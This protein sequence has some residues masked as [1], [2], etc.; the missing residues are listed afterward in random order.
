MSF[1]RADPSDSFVRRLA[2]MAEHR[3]IPGGALLCTAGEPAPALVLIASGLVE[4]VADSQP[5]SGV[6]GCGDPADGGVC[7]VSLRARTEVHSIAIP[8][9]ALLA[10]G[11]LDGAAVERVGS[12]IVQVLQRW[13]LV[14]KAAALFGPLDASAIRQLEAE[15]RWITLPRGELLVRQGDRGDSVFVLLAGRLQ[16][17]LEDPSGGRTP[18][19]EIAT[20]EIIG[21][22]SFFTGEPRSA[23]LCAVRDSL[24]IEIPHGPLERLIAARPEILRQ[25]VRVQIDRVRR[26][27]AGRIARAPVTNIAV[28]P[29]TPEVPAAA[30]CRRLE[31]ALARFGRVTHLDPATVNARL[32]SAT[33]A[34]TPEGAPEETRL[35]AWL[36][37]QELDARFVVYENTPGHDDWLSRSIHQADCV[38]LLG[39]ATD[40]PDVTPFERRAAQEEDADAPVRRVLVL[41]HESDTLPNDTQAWLRARPVVQHHHLRWHRDGDVARLARFLADQ[42]VGIVLGGGG[43]RGFAHIGILKALAEAGIP[44]DLIGGTSMGAAMAAQ[45]AMGW[46]P[47][48]IARTNDHIWNTIKP[49]KEYTLPILSLVRAG[50]ALRCGQM[51]YGSSRIED[52]WLPFFCVSSDLT[53]AA[54]HVHRSGPLL[55]AITASSSLP[56][57][58]VPTVK[59]GHL[60]CD[61]ALFN[62]LPGDVAREL[63]CGTL[64]ALRVSLEQDEAF[65]Y[66]RIP[67]LWEVLRTKVTRR[68]LRY[69]GLGDVL[70]RGAMLASIGRENAVARSADLLFVPPVAQYG[71]ME[72]S[73]L[74]RLVETGYRYAVERITEWERTG[75]LDRV[76][77]GAASC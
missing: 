51:M 44:T 61:G 12:L 69:P 3:S 15:V 57:V 60:L 64:I 9:E 45:H 52:L 10:E 11:M 27:N 70:L 67:S 7:R 32:Q 39:R 63:G 71:L 35:L 54:M 75:V 48:R 56:G 17:L 65:R 59:D 58:I 36:G 5:Y 31:A 46:S 62:N 23:S 49:H 30:F 8:S 53:A 24:L 19:G 26:A 18:V 6:V 38:L 72:F 55:E 76:P 43:A 22:M 20:G 77:H 1:A 74:D 42:A 66:A 29:L 28:V 21:E 68:P 4:T 34:H 33:I 50:G 37:E 73:A 40:P 25:V 41:L 16:A 2:A 14:A 13:D 47:E